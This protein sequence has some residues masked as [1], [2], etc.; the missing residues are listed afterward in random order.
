MTLK[1][2]EAIEG[3]L[4]SAQAFVDAFNS[5]PACASAKQTV[6][7]AKVKLETAIL[8]STIEAEISDG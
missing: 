2:E 8:K 4:L 3:L 1:K 6:F 5:S 7:N